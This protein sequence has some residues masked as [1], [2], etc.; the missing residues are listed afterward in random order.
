MPRG[1]T[2]ICTYRVRPDKAGEFESLLRRHWPTLRDAELVTETA[3]LQFR[4]Q[5]QDGAPYFIEI[6]EWV[7]ADAPHTAHHIPAVMA[8]WEPMGM[9]CEKRG[10]RPP[11]EFPIV[12]PI[13]RNG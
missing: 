8:V 6:L 9:C 11:M 3:P 2:A 5:E 7:S 4:G 1:A 13:P 12:D 10:D